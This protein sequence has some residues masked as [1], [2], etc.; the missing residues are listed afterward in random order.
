MV[1]IP[2]HI[3]AEINRGIEALK[4]HD[5][6]GAVDHFQRALDG[7]EGVADLESRRDEFANMA[8]LFCQLDVPDLGLLAAR[9]AVA[10][11]EQLND[12]SL[13]AQDTHLCGVAMHR[14]GSLAGAEQAYRDARQIFI[15]DKDWA[16]AAS[17]TTNLAILVGQ[18][19]IKQKIEL[20]E[21]SLVYLGRYELPDTEITTRIALIQALVVDNRPSERVFEVATGLLERFLNR[22]RPDQRQNSI[23]PLE[24]AIDRYL[25]KHPDV[26]PVVWKARSFPM[27]YG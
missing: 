14:L 13:F 23:G 17:A 25:A 4:V 6:G 22:L 21:E 9:E 26:D 3:W 8:M 15:D 10:I 1:D 24:Q 12:R 2:S 11:D 18:E 16:N 27:L 20:L 5:R 19:D 7:L